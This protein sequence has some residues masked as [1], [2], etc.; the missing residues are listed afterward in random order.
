MTR[1]KQIE[2]QTFVFYETCSDEDI[3]KSKGF[4]DG[5]KWA[6]E[7]PREGLVDIEK[8]CEWWSEVPDDTYGFNPCRIYM[9]DFRKAMGVPS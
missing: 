7:H 5:A 6:D 3:A 9:D 4:I 8:V 2:Q 1:E